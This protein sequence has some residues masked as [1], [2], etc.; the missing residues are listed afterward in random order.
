MLNFP[1]PPPPP[2]NLSQQALMDLA[3]YYRNLAEYHEQAASVANQQL[4]H[5][6]ALLKPMLQ[7][8]SQGLSAKEFTLTPPSFDESYKTNGFVEMIAVTSTATLEP[9]EEDEKQQEKEDEVV[10]TNKKATTKAN[11]TTGKKANTKTSTRAKVKPSAKAVIIPS[12]NI[13]T[14]TVFK[15]EEELPEEPHEAPSA[16]VEKILRE[17]EQA[18]EPSPSKSTSKKQKTKKPRENFQSKRPPNSRLPFSPKLDQCGSLTAAIATVLKENSPSAMNADK[19]LQWL[20]PDDLPID[21]R[22]H[23]RSSI[24]HMLNQGCDYKGWKRLRPGEYVWAR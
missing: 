14:K 10:T 21:E 12:T 7:V 6:E 4:T 2:P 20:Y 9:E 18:D 11:N 1:P 17:L 5:L 23:V 16:E 3:N 13:I 24:L 8:G 22:K 15:E 19:V